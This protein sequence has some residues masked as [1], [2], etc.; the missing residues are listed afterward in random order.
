MGKQMNKPHCG[1]RLTYW[2]GK[3]PQNKKNR[4]N[5]VA[6]LGLK[7]RLSSYQYEKAADWP[8]LRIEKTAEYFGVSRDEFLG[9]EENKESD[10][11]LVLEARIRGLESRV[12]ELERRLKF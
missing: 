10:N 3:F 5:Y 6:F 11:G 9:T 8:N 7:S 12:D 1:E 2:L 4:T